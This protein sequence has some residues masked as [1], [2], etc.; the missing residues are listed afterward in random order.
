[1]EQIVVKEVAEDDLVSIADFFSDLEDSRSS[2]NRK[3]LLT[4]IIVI[5]IAGILS[6]CDGPKAIGRWAQSK[7]A[8]C[9]KHLELPNGIPSYHTI[10][11]VLAALKPD[12]FEACFTQW[13]DSLANHS[14]FIGPRLP[15][16]IAID[17]KAVRRSHDHRNGLKALFLVSAWAVHNGLSLGQLATEEKSNEITAIP[18]LIDN[19]DIQGTIVT[20]DAAGCQKNIAKKII[21]AEGDYVLAL[22]GNQGNLHRDIVAWIEGQF[23]NDWEGIECQLLETAEKGHGREDMISYVQVAVPEDLQG[24]E[25]WAKLKSIGVATRVSCS[26]DKET[27]DRRYYLSSLG[28]NVSHL[29]KLVRGHWAIENTLHWCLDMTFR[30]DESR[31][32]NRIAATNVAWLKRFAIGL[33]KRNG[34]KESIAMQRRMAGWNEDYLTQILGLKTT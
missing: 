17:G 16:Q 3:H 12:A 7:Q 2:I 27:V 23:E 20:I 34:S 19:L 26:G 25:Q 13:T 15:E 18:E 4:D 1:M 22:K 8:W 5:A 10:A 6:G 14:E 33:I 21:D 24:R 29:A 30:E 9:A 31:L 11:R 28:V 32:R